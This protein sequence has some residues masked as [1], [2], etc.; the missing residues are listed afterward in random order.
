MSYV[1]SSV[2]FSGSE[3]F[4]PPKPASVLELSECWKWSLKKRAFVTFYQESHHSIFCWNGRWN[5]PVSKETLF[6][7]VWGTII[8]RKPE[9]SWENYNQVCFSQ[10]LKWSCKTEK[11]IF[12]WS[13]NFLA[14]TLYN[15]GFSRDTES[16][17]DY[18][19]IYM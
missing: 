9:V 13:D 8:I 3:I 4:Y 7:D 1:A 18:I 5:P 17:G 15:S 16:I 10:S 6:L 11:K 2:F 19:Y 14:S 12:F